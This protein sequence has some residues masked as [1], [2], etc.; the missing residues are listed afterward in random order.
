MCISAVVALASCM[1]ATEHIQALFAGACN[2]A[3]TLLCMDITKLILL[4][5][6]FGKEI[7]LALASVLSQK[8]MKADKIRFGSSDV[9]CADW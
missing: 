3:F 2:A 6:W 9:R 8:Y 4:I 1:F 5:P 7:A